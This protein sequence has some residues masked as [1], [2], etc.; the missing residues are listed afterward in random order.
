[1]NRKQWYRWQQ[2]RR[3]ALLVSSEEQHR[4][5]IALVSD[6][7]PQP[8]ADAVFEAR[9]PRNEVLGIDSASLCREARELDRQVGGHA[10]WF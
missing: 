4:R 8:I 9:R 5:Q 10:T 2:N 6:V 3:I 7:Q 1:M